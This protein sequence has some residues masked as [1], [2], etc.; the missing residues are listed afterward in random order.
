MKL[1]NLFS[2]KD[3]EQG[4]IVYVLNII[5]WTQTDFFCAWI[6]NTFCMFQLFPICS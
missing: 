3:K 1:F 6:N 4:H 2:C 5:L